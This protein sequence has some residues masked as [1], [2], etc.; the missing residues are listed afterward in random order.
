MKLYPEG[1]FLNDFHRKSSLEG[2]KA[3]KEM[4]KHPLSLEEVKAQIARH[5]EQ[6]R[7]ANDSKKEI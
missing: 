3:V 6:I 2:I 1:Y 4:M 7:N 5:Q